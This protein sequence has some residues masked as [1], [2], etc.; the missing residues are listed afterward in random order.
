MN[1]IPNLFLCMLLFTAV[2]GETLRPEFYSKTCP[3][4][5][6]IVREE[7]RKAM[8]K[9]ARSVASVMRFQFHDCFVNVN[10][11]LTTFQYIKFLKKSSL[12]SYNLMLCVL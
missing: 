9:E 7:M 2:A 10:K 8:M 5:E 4:V 3:K 1:L 6:S 12:E 11:S